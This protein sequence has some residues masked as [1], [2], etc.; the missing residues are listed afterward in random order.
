MAIDCTGYY[1]YNGSAQTPCTAGATG[2]GLSQPLTVSYS[3]NTSAGTATASASFAGDTNH[4]GN[5][6]STTFTIH[7]AS[8]TVAVSCTGGPFTYN[9]SPQTPSC[10]A[11]VTGAGG[12]SQPVTPVTF[13]NNTNAGTATAGASFSGDTNHT[14]NTGST[15]FTIGQ[16]GST[17][18]VTCTGG[19][20]TYTGSPLTPC[21]ATSSTGAPLTPTY[22]NNTNVGTATASATFAGDTNDSGSSSSATFTITPANF[23]V[24]VNSDDA[25]TASNCTPQ[26]AAGT[27]TDSTCSL[28]DALLLSASAGGGNISFDGTAF[29][30]AKTITLSNGTLTLPT[31]TTISGAISSMYTTCVISVSS[32]STG[33]TISTQPCSQTV[34]V[35][36]KASFSVAA[37]GTNPLSYQWQYLNSNSHW[38]SFGAGTGTTTSSLTTFATTAAYN[39]LQLRVVITDGNSNTT[40]SNAVTLTAV[41]DLTTANLVTVDGSNQ[42]PVFTDRQHDIRKQH[43]GYRRRH[44]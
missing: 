42:Y 6:N 24:T 37:T 17:V 25:G 18:T 4:T 19:P 23:V 3:S 38:V 30:S 12:L 9:G 2:P 1:T 8:S 28:R 26:T 40:T 16:A 34:P 44:L 5:S 15:T 7:Q 43:R 11:S 41:S 35:G 31:G 14:G 21:S 13:S 20:F 22:S 10:T 39:G 27:G 29:A 33:P 36:T 32:P